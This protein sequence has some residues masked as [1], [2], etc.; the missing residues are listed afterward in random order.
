MV[1]HRLSNIRNADRICVLQH[2]RLVQ[3]GSF[4]QLA[5]E[6]GLFSQLI[7]RQRL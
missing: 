3:Q 6:E 7:Q 5:R 2:G 1:A 4:E